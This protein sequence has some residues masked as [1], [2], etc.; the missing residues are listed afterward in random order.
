VKVP[1]TID[2]MLTACKKVNHK[3][4]PAITL[5]GIRGVH[6]NIWIFNIFYYGEGGTYYKGQHP[7]GAVPTGKLQADMNTAASLKGMETFADFFLDGYT[8]AGSGNY[9]YPE[10][11]STFKSGKAAMFVDDVVFGIEMAAALGDKV[12]F[13]PAP[14]GPSGMYPGFDA[15]MYFLAKGSNNKEAAVAF[16][17][18]ATSTPIQLAAAKNG[19]YVGVTRD[20]VFNAPAF[21]KL[22]RPDLVTAFKGVEAHL[23]INHFPQTA[24]FNVVGDYMSIAVN[25]VITGTA[26]AK[27]ALA[28]AQSQAVSYLAAHQS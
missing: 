5:R 27:S 26:K 20:S 14:I 12:G 9:D 4:V 16:M 22:I 23:D 28:S 21:Q 8:P 2:E 19:S 6:S 13:A 17:A 24:S 1:T 10:T 25:E 15:Q 11:S 7:G 18:W 3:P